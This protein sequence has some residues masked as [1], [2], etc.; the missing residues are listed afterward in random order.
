MQRYIDGN[1]ILLNFFVKFLLFVDTYT[2]SETYQKEGWFILEDENQVFGKITGTGDDNKN[3]ESEDFIFYN[4]N[5][6]E[7]KKNLDDSI[8]DLTEFIDS[9]IGDM[10]QLPE[11]EV[12]SGV[13]KILAVTHPQEV[14]KTNK[15]KTIT[16]RVLFIAALI[17]IL[18]VSCLLVVG[19]NHNI[20]IKNGF[21]TFAKDTIKIVFFG[22]EK[23]ESITVDALLTDLRFHGYDDILFPQEFITNSDDYK[24]SVPVYSEDVLRQAMFDIYSETSTYSFAIYDYDQNQKFRDFDNIKA[25]ETIEVNGVI[26]YLFE[27]DTGLSAIEFAC[28]EYSF[29][30]HSFAPYSEVVEIAKTLR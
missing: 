18:S 4:R 21:V 30:I 5:K 25:A 16:R 1:F 13:E 11:E 22:E 23:E 29:Y 15:K 17:S 27:F 2:K 3:L 9:L 24:V 8:E 7:A 10:P 14:R 20:S 28:G 12:N 19:S 6:E 26:I